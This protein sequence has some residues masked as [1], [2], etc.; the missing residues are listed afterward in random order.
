M[1]CGLTR[2]HVVHYTMFDERPKLPN[3]LKNHVS[4]S[5][6]QCGMGMVCGLLVRYH[7][8]FFLLY[9]IIKLH[10]IDYEKDI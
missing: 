6:Y 10:I 9:A 3:C 5:Y 8:V 2:I 1:T 7:I 4:Y